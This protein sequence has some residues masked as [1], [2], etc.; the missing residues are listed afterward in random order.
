M[1]IIVTNNIER[2]IKMDGILEQILSELKE[3]KQILAKN[4]AINVFTNNTEDRTMKAKEAAKY[5]GITEWALRTFTKQGKI[6]HVMVGN[7]YIYRKS[8]L[9]EW[10]REALETSVK[11]DEEPTIKGTIRKV[12]E[13]PIWE[14]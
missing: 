8:A 11:T 13:R 9:D 4:E 10:L 7:R 1:G 6:K 14:K 12:S 2:K 5:A 3:I